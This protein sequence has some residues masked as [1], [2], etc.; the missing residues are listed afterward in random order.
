MTPSAKMTEAPTL[1]IPKALLPSDGRFGCGP[2]K[3]R[4]AQLD[5]LASEGRAVMGTS[6]RQAPVKSLVARTRERP[7]RAV[8]AARRLRGRARERRRQRVLGCGRVRAR[9][10]PRAPFDLR[11]VLEQVRLGDEGCAVPRG[12]DRDRRSG[13]QRARAGELAGGRRDRLGAQRDLDRRDARSGA[14]G[15][16]R[17]CA[18]RDRRDLRR[19][20]AAA[21]RSGRGRLLLRAAEELR[22]GRRAVDRADEPGGASSA[23]DAD[24]G[25]GAVDPA[26]PVADVAL[27]NS[28]KEQ[29]NNTPAVATLFML[30]DQIEWMLEAAGSTG[31][32]RGP[33]I[34]CLPLRLGRGV[35]ARVAVCQRS[36]TALASSSGRSTSTRRWTLRR[37][38]RRSAR[39][40]SST[41]SPTASSGATSCESRC[42]RRS[43]PTTCVR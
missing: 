15:R 10:S 5:R 13:R 3:I 9:R 24:R 12:P 42:S 26:V 4:D 1:T 28:L 36:G 38:R 17:A 37:L 25:V 35:A 32:C 8:R 40:A 27:E 31:A 22:L 21:G 7:A 34:C 39:T 41:S 43:S 11:R 14:P 19:R 16:E 2:S 20:R 18:G 30:A 6:H 29:T 33:E 23:I